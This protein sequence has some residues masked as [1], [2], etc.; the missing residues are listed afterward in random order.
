[1]VTTTLKEDMM[2]PRYKMMM[3]EQRRQEESFQNFDARMAFRFG[4]VCTMYVRLHANTNT[5]KYV[6]EQM[7]LNRPKNRRSE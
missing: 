3:D 2:M 6:N 7:E 1:M 5:R 4:C